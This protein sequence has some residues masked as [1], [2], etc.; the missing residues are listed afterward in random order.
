MPTLYL[1][2]PVEQIFHHLYLM[3]Y[4]GSNILPNT[5]SGSI[6]E[7]IECFNAL[8]EILWFVTRNKIH[9]EVP[10]FYRA[11]SL[12]HHTRYPFPDL[13]LL[14]YENWLATTDLS[15]TLRAGFT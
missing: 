14:L 2:I 6:T 3:Q 12:M 4:L 7:S 15:A 10:F 9:L 5:S 13:I 11:H 1:T 8:I